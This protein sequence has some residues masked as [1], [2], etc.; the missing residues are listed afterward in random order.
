MLRGHGLTP[1]G[2]PL[3]WLMFPNCSLRT[4]A[5]G[6][7]GESRP[8]PGLEP[9]Q[10]GSSLPQV[11]VK[12]AQLQGRLGD[13]LWGRGRLLAPSPAMGARAASLPQ[14]VEGPEEQ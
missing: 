5:L 10:R 4:E 14:T 6:S 12:T 2:S 11:R 7:L 1:K 3:C 9:G 8:C 13:L